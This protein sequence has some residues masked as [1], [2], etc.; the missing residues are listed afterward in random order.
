MI[1]HVFY[2]FH[3][4]ND[5]DRVMAVRNRWVTY[6]TQSA[7]QLIDSAAFERIKRNGD[8]A[9]KEWIK[10]QM[11]NTSATI[12]LIGAQTLERPYVQ[13]E[14]CETL[15]NHKALIG[16]YINNIK[17]LQRQISSACSESTIIGTDPYGEPVTFKQVADG[18]YDYARDGGYWNLNKWVENALEKHRR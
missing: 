15:N 14:I 4:N 18:I 3:Y 8:A 11:K 6:R 5:I 9:V 1:R 13:Y 7:S 16:V 12:V 10:Q 17:N 2:S